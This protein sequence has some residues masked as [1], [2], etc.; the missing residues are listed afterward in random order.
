MASLLE[1]APLVLAVAQLA[2]AERRVVVSLPPAPG[3]VTQAQR[4][5]RVLE[6]AQSQEPPASSR[7]AAEW[8]VA[9][10]VTRAQRALPV[11]EQVSSQELPGEFPLAQAQS[12]LR[13][14]WILL[15]LLA[16]QLAARE[17]R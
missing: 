15:W 14:C 10:S 17:Q 6:R 7:L 4:S 16:A 9:D 11:S 13:E 8:R 2:V 5:L 3:F 1:R 12:L